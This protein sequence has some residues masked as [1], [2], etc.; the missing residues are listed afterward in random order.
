MRRTTGILSLLFLFLYRAPAQS[1]DLPALIT[2]A[3]T[4]PE[5]FH[6]QLAHYLT[7]HTNRFDVAAAATNGWQACLTAMIINSRLDHPAEYQVV[8]TPTPSGNISLETSYMVLSI[9]NKFDE[10]SVYDRLWKGGQLS[11]R[12]M[13]NFGLTNEFGLLPGGYP[14]G[15]LSRTIWSRLRLSNVVSTSL[16]INILHSDAPSELKG[17]AAYGLTQRDTA[18]AESALLPVLQDTNLPIMMKRAVFFGIEFFAPT[19]GWQL[20]SD[21]RSNWEFETNGNLSFTGFNTVGTLTD[22]GAANFISNSVTD[23]NLP[24]YARANA[25]DVLRPKLANPLAFYQSLLLDTNTPPKLAQAVSGEL[26]KFS[27]S[28]VTNLLQQL[29]LTRFDSDTQGDL[30]VSPLEPRDAGTN[31]LQYVRSLSQRTDLS[32]DARDQAASAAANFAFRNHLPQ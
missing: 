3:Q 15:I 2:L 4:P 27:A 5:Q 17:F 26:Y 11:G 12:D 21:S 9:S 22:L 7:T 6:T 25:L 30:V 24:G 8:D 10:A 23:T 28:A 32:Q 16:L 31:E 29:D 19:Y 20:M 18:D 13:T 14:E 1:I